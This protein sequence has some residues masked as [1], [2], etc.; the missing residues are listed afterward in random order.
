MSDAPADLEGAC[1]VDGGMIDAHLHVV[2]AAACAD[3]LTGNPN[4]RWWEQVDSSPA[5]VSARVRAAGV[6]GGVLVQAVGAHGYDN[7]LVVEAARSLGDDWRAMAA[8]G[9]RSEDPVSLLE[10]AAA[11]GASGLRLFSIPDPW[12]HDDL[13]VDLLHRCRDLGVGASVCCLPDELSAVVRLAASAP[14]CE[15]AVDHCGFTAVGGD[16]RALVGLA[17]CGNLVVKLSSWVFEAAAVG[18]RSVVSRLF[19]LFGAG[20]VVWG[21]DHPQVRDRAYRELVALAVDATCGLDPATR[22]AVL[23]RTAARL[24]FGR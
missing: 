10:G 24:W 17:G 13:A 19:G 22:A 7:S 2:D 18:P 15:I 4:V 21:S 6:S 9:R 8:V 5:A 16:D 14:D 1:S 11:Q 3:D 23:G 12:L 20:R